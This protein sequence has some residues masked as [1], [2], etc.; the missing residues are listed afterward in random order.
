MGALQENSQV[1]TLKLKIHRH[2]IS[3]IRRWVADV[4]LIVNVDGSVSIEVFE[5]NVS[6]RCILILE[7]AAFNFLLI[8]ENTIGD[9][10][11]E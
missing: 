8:L 4:R 10:T 3:N 2:A 11:I 6:R 9:I 1:K 7:C 5:A